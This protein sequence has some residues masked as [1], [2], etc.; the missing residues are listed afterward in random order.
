MTIAPSIY[1]SYT[2]NVLFA[3]PLLFIRCLYYVD[4]LYHF[5]FAEKRLFAIFMRKNR[6]SYKNDAWKLKRMGAKWTTVSLAFSLYKLSSN[7]TS[8]EQVDDPWSRL[9]VVLKFAAR[10]V[11][12]FHHAN[13]IWT[14]EYIFLGTTFQTHKRSHCNTASFQVSHYETMVCFYF[15]I[16]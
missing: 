9:Y 2:R 13:P 11:P 3:C 12:Q 1:L 6:W 16:E 10:C 15:S 14:R 5:F 7:P 4:V 8:F